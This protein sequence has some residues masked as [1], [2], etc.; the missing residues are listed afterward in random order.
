LFGVLAV[1]QLEVVA[2]V[3]EA[4]IATS[5]LALEHLAKE[6]L[7]VLV[8]LII[9][10]M[11]VVAVVALVVLVALVLLHLAVMAVLERLG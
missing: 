7:E 4:L 9:L 5:Q 11:A 6:M 8:L 3:L 10:L 2:L 1:E